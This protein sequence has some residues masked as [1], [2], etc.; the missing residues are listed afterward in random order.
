[1]EQISSI[2]FIYSNT[3]YITNI[4]I[5]EA[6]GSVEGRAR[7]NPVRDFL[8]VERRDDGQLKRKKKSL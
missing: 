1:L 6:A 8:S 5:D 4:L 7:T 2:H 3:I